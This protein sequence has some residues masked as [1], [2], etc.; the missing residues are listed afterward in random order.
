MLIYF[1]TKHKSI[2]NIHPQA[3]KTNQYVETKGKNPIVKYPDSLKTITIIYIIS[4][5]MSAILN[6]FIFSEIRIF[7]N[8]IN[9]VVRQAE[10]KK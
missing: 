7:D 4:K 2:V 9:I 3:I 8:L 5:K 1:L 10:I 6:I